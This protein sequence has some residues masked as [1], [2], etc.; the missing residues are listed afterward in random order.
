[1]GGLALGATVAVTAMFTG[2]EVAKPTDEENETLQQAYQAYFESMGIKD[3][4]PGLAL[5]GVVA[6]YAAPRLMQ[7]KARQNMAEFGRKVL[8]AITGKRKVISEI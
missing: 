6:L 5:M 4:P 2:L 1:M 7:E 8:T 3:L